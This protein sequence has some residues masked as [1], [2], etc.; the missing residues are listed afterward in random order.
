MR[1][2]SLSAMIGLFYLFIYLF[3]YFFLYLFLDFFGVLGWE[4][5]YLKHITIPLIPMHTCYDASGMITQYVGMRY[6][7]DDAHKYHSR[8]HLHLQICLSL[9]HTEFGTFLF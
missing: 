7:Y 3:V 9:S 2:G 6:E 8:W 4:F 1:K 5:N